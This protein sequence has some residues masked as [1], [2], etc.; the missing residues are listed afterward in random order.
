MERRARYVA[1][2]PGYRADRFS[3]RGRSSERDGTTS[4]RTVAAFAGWRRHGARFGVSLGRP[5]AGDGDE[6][7]RGALRGTGG[8]VHRDKRA[9]SPYDTRP[10][11]RPSM[12]H[13]STARGASTAAEARAE[14]PC[15]GHRLRS[16]PDGQ[17]PRLVY[18]AL[19]LANLKQS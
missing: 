17:P 1:E 14:G 15:A 19:Q 12:L 10:W 4:E 16:I 5:A 18:Q 9:R 3:P 7:L 8:T 13:P 2:Y 11:R 6:R